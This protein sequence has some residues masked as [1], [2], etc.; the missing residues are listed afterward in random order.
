MEYSIVFPLMKSESLGESVKRVDS[1][2]L[3]NVAGAVSPRSAKSRP[4]KSQG[5]QRAINFLECVFWPNISLK[6]IELEAIH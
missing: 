1:V 4:Y 6:F 2:G 3:R 5:H